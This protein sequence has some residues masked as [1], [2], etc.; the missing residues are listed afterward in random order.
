MLYGDYDLDHYSA[1]S[2]GHGPFLIS[3]SITG[4]PL[5][6]YQLFLLLSWIV[7]ELTRSFSVGIV[8]M[9]DKLNH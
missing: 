8:V 7:N 3:V 4:P 6:F 9:V 1:I 2:V 5:I